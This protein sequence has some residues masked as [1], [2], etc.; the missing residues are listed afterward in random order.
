MGAQNLPV[1]VLVKCEL[2]TIL[3]SPIRGDAEAFDAFTLA[4]HSLKGMLRT[5]EGY[6]GY[7]LSCESHVDQLL[8]KKPPSYRDGFVEY[9]LQS[10]K[11]APTRTYTLPDLAR[12]ATC[13]ISGEMHIWQKSHT[14]TR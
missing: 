13:E 10:F 5:L 7:E 4:V 12:V 3:N 2:G 11:A 9:C 1:P 8:S 6:R 14:S